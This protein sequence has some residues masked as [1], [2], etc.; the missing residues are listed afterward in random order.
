[1]SENT[2]RFPGQRRDAPADN[3]IDR[4]GDQV[5]EAGKESFPSSDPPASWAGPDEG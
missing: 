2:Q 1:M 5:D 3:E 4:A